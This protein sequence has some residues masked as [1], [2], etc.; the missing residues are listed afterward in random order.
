VNAK[1]HLRAVIAEYFVVDDRV[2]EDKLLDL[3][4]T[5]VTKPT[6]EQPLI[7]QSHL[8][9]TRAHRLYNTRDRDLTD[10]DRHYLDQVDDFRRRSR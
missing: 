4:V 2:Q 6:E 8:E 7:V 10:E 3:L 1:D 5:A 9:G